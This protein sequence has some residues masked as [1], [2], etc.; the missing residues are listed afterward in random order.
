[1]NKKIKKSKD[2]STSSPLKVTNIDYKTLIKNG[3]NYY[4]K[5]RGD[6]YESNTK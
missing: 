6:K 4:F 5:S 3:D 2:F 1:M